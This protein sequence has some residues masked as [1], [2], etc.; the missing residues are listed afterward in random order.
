M[1][2]PSDLLLYMQSTLE[3]NRKESAGLETRSKLNHIPLDHGSHLVREHTHGHHQ[4]GDERD[5]VIA[6][7]QAPED[8]FIVDGEHSVPVP[9]A[10]H[11]QHHLR[12]KSV[13]K[14]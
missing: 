7:E 10:Y 13:Q 14:S 5:D 2:R 4:R 8:L 12:R 11:L 3:K 1:S 6:D 9:I